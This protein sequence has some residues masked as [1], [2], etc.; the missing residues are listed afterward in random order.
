MSHQGMVG[1][2][3]VFYQSISP[4]LESVMD[5]LGGGGEGYDEDDYMYQEYLDE[6]EI[7]DD[8]NEFIF[9]NWVAENSPDCPHFGNFIWCPTRGAMVWDHN[10]ECYVPVSIGA[11]PWPYPNVPSPKLQSTFFEK[12]STIDELAS[13]ILTPVKPSLPWRLSLCQV[14]LLP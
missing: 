4:G 6:K 8:Q 12:S 10:G 1:Q 2:Q 3:G 9:S 13:E 14:C 5:M 7:I 11:T